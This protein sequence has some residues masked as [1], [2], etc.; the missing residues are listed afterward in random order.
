MSKEKWTVDEV[1][2][3]I[4]T[5][6]ALTFALIAAIEV[7]LYTDYDDDDAPVTGSQHFV[8]DQKAL[9]AIFGEKLHEQ[10]CLLSDFVKDGMANNKNR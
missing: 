6:R 9:L 10:F 5:T 1:L 2:D 3:Q 8:I 4:E 7:P